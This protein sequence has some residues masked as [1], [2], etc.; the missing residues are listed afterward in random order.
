[1]LV[2]VSIVYEV[3][4]DGSLGPQILPFGKFNCHLTY[5][6]D[7]ATVMDSVLKEANRRGVHFKLNISEKQEWLIN[8]MG[9]NGLPD[10]QG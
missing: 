8:H 5:R 7:A 4:P 9:A 10:P 3:L 6:A 1:M 2:P